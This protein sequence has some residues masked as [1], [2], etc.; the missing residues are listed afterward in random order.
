MKKKPIHL[1]KSLLCFLVLR[2]GSVNLRC[3]YS[4]CCC[5]ECLGV[6]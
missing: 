6:C 4:R 2:R 1:F 5:V 3:K